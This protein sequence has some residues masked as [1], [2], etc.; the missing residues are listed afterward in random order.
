[1]DGVLV[2]FADYTIGLVNKLIAGGGIP[3][4]AEQTE[5]YRK[6]LRRIHNRLEP[7]F[8]VTDEKQLKEKP[9]IKSFMFGVIGTNPGE[10][11]KRM[12]PYQDMASTKGHRPRCLYIKCRCACKSRES[13]DF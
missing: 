11:Y 13:Y 5:G 1:M 6:R 12:S 7:G 2:N 8:R 10:F 9:E 4:G 3:W